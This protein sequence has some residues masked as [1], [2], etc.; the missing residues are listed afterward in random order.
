LEFL[1]FP[2]KASSLKQADLTDMFK[3]ASKRVC[4]LTVVVFHDYLLL[5]QLL[6]L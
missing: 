3:K 1:P 2:E 4:V 6:E 5:H